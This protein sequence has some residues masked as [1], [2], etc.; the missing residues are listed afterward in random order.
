MKACFSDSSRELSKSTSQLYYLWTRDL[1]ENYTASDVSLEV[2]QF[3][4]DFS[5]SRIL[6]SKKPE[7]A[8]DELLKR[9]KWLSGQGTNNADSLIE[10]CSI[11]TRKFLETRPNVV[12]KDS[13]RNFND[14]EKWILWLR[15]GKKCLLC[16]TA[17]PDYRSAHADHILPHAK[18]G[19][20]EL[21]NGRALCINCNL[22]KG[23][24]S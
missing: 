15:A 22:V 11:L 5:E 6:D 8:Q 19:K 2:K 1:K 16:G 9:F 3:I 24:K 13:K 4:E 23:A 20:T 14:E 21:S 17:L 7:S 18:G 10:R 12:P